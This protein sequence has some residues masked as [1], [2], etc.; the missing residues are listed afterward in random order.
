MSKS[1]VIGFIQARLTSSRLPNKVLSKIGQWTTL[2]LM[3]KRLKHAKTLDKIVV[4]IPDNTENDAL[5]E[6]IDRS[7]GIEFVRGDE[8]DV[9]GRFHKASL[10]FPSDYY[11]RMTGDCPLLPAEIVDAV[12]TMTVLD[13]ADYGSNAYPPTFPD[14]FDVECVSAGALKWAQEN[15]KQLSIREHVTLGLHK[16]K[17]SARSFKFS[18]YA[19]KTPTTEWMRITLDSPAD[20]EVFQQLAKKF[21]NRLLEVQSTEIEDAYADLRLLQ[22]NGHLI[23]N[24]ALNNLQEDCK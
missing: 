9:L 23:R 17:S 6:Y 11:V 15:I 14:G 18:N 24:T 7:L 1:R 2:E 10:L 16:E 21:G 22:L 8:H 19:R 13:N 5:A 20:L 4:L 12:V 3:V